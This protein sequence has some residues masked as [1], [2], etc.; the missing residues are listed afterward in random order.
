MI[1]C[2]IESDM[3]AF[4]YYLEAIATGHEIGIVF[5]FFIQGGKSRLE[6][7]ELLPVVTEIFLELRNRFQ[8]IH[9]AIRD[10]LTRVWVHRG[11]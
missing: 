8:L 11:V 6:L 5:V 2:K 7:R 3:N 4:D 10:Q 1:P 9:G